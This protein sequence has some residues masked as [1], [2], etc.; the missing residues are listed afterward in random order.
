M[1]PLNHKRTTSSLAPPIFYVAK[2]LQLKDR[3][4]PIVSTK[5]S[6][7]GTNFGTSNLIFYLMKKEKEIDLLIKCFPLLFPITISR[8]YYKANC[9]H[10][11][12]MY[13]AGHNQ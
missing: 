10:K 3:R 6:F 13:I 9:V 12:Q 11:K 5:K 4:F 2:K 7:F 1:S 8:Q